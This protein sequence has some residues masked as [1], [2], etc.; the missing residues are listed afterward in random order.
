[1]TERTGSALVQDIHMCGEREGRKE[2]TTRKVE[3]EEVEETKDKEMRRR[4]RYPP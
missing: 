1:M 4:R 2:A 3:E